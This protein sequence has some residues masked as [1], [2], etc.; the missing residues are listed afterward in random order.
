MGTRLVIDSAELKPLLEAAGLRR[1]EDFLTFGG[2]VVVARSNTT[3]TRRVELAGNGERAA[4]FLK[5]YHH[6][7]PGRRRRLFRDK[8]AREARNYRLLRERCGAPVPEV[9]AH[10]ARRRGWRI[11]D[12]F[13]MTRGIDLA[14]SL[15]E[16]VAAHW[17]E[18]GRAGEAR[19]RRALLRDT[20]ELIARMHRAAF[21]HIDLQWRNLLVA[22]ESPDRPRLYVLDCVRGGLRRTALGQAHGRV[23]DLSSLHKDGR[24]W[25]SAAEQLRWLRNYLGVRRLCAEGK[26]LARAV[27]H[28]RRT[29]DA[30]S[31]R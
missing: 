9:V 5:T 22:L 29:K 26:A 15:D 7:G 25:L 4:V 20:A 3:T 1:C 2:G 11:V 16:F 30:E 17:P 19:L 28:D 10:G 6:D 12:S 8:C 21:F 27:L 24:R 13:I 23:R 14:C 18:A 31:R